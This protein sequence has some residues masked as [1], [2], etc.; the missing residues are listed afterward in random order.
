MFPN[1]LNLKRF[2]K[3]R[4][5]WKH[6]QP[7]F[8]ISVFISAPVLQTVAAFSQ[9]CFV[10]IVKI[11]SLPDPEMELGRS[12]TTSHFNQLYINTINIITSWNSSLYRIQMFPL[13]Q[14]VIIV[15]KHSSSLWM[16]SACISNANVFWYKR[17][18]L[19]AIWDMIWFYSIKTAKQI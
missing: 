18:A 16:M 7:A 11:P 14:T 9:S 1:I 15:S 8:L 19:S 12:Q 6:R 3:T 17:N 10:C 13:N 4:L 5:E 2:I